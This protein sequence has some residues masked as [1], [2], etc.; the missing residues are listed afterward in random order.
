MPITI[1]E[2]KSPLEHTSFAVR[3]PASIFQAFD[4]PNVNPVMAAILQDTGVVGTITVMRKSVMIWFGWG[5]LE[6]S[7][8]GQASNAASA[9]ESA[10]KCF[11]ISWF[12]FNF[13]LTACRHASLF[14]HTFHTVAQQH[15]RKSSHGTTYCRHAANEISRSIF[16]GPGSIVNEISGRPLRGRGALVSTNGQSS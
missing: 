16:L 8:Q 7:S 12:P 5:K 3:L 10:C 1:T 11:I 9:V 13:F 15:S 4:E 6:S 2:T 14:P